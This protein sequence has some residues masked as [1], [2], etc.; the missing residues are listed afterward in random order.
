[1]AGLGGVISTHVLDTSR[2]LPAPGVHVRLQHLL[3][4]GAP[5]DA[6]AGLTDRDGRI[7]A[8]SD[9][10]LTAGIYRL[11]FDLHGYADG[12]FRSVSLEIHVGDPAASYH[13]PLLVAPFGISTYRGS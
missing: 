10:P 9:A 11:T 7:R 2:G 12:F 1:V 4:D 6:G 5:V 8:L 3:A 13:V